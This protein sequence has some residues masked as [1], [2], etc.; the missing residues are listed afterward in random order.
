[1]DLPNHK[2]HWK[3]PAPIPDPEVRARPRGGIQWQ[4]P[5]CGNLHSQD[6]HF[7]RRAQLQCKR[8]G[9]E[10]KF[11]I[12]VGFG[13]QE[14]DYRAFMMGFWELNT[15]NRKNPDYKYPLPGRLFGIIDWECPNCFKIHT[16][17]VDFFNPTVNCC[18]Y[19]GIYLLLYRPSGSKNITPYDWAIFTPDVSETH[20]SPTS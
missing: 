2:P 1:M 12:G 17:D 6:K 3:G 14:S 19:W 5:D 4:C 8:P 11:R 9:C 13:P 20:L 16:S 7:W 10:H 15:A 18:F